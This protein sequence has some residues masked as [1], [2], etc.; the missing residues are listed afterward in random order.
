MLFTDGETGGNLAIAPI[1]TENDSEIVIQYHAL[2]LSLC[3]MVNAYPYDVPDFMPDVICTLAEHVN[4]PPPI[5]STIKRTLS[6]FKRT[7]HDNWRNHKDKFTE[8]QLTV[9]TDLVV[10][11]SYYA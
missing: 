7:H 4:A 3:A 6:D 11:P 10:S 5:A 9:I 2:V 8:E 1:V